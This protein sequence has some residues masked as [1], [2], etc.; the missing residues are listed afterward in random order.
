MRSLTLV[1]FLVCVVFASAFQSSRRLSTRT[2]SK[3]S[4]QAVTEEAACGPCPLA[5]KCKGE[6][7][8]KGESD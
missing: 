1:V 8:T 3:V 5:P 2:F 6:Y 7:S 4:R